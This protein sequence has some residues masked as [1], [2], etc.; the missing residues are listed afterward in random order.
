M[1][2]VQAIET[3]IDR[4]IITIGEL[5]KTLITE[6]MWTILKQLTFLGWR[7]VFR[8]IVFFT[9]IFLGFLHK[10][11]FE[12]WIKNHRQRIRPVAV[13][14]EWVHHRHDPSNPRNDVVEEPTFFSKLVAE[15]EAIK[16]AEEDA[17]KAE[18]KGDE[19]NALC[20]PI[21]VLLL[22]Q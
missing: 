12:S 11:A 4:T 10:P 20:M 18:P 19:P 13:E 22:T 16:S 17:E 21:Y 1:T 2:F 14:N 7:F 8:I 3:K 9:T 6:C 15:V 5:L